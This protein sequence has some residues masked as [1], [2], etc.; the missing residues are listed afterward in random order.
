MLVSLR[1]VKLRRSLT[2]TSF[3]LVG[4]ATVNAIRSAA[5]VNENEPDIKSSGCE[6]RTTF[7]VAGST[8]NK[9]DAVFCDPAKYIS[10]RFHS[11]KPGF[12]SKESV[13]DFGVPPSMLT[14]A[15]RELLAK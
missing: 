4:D 7:A 9:C 13:I 5:R 8:R 10:L 15:R 1:G 2:K 12:S 6:R 3:M 11:S 14:I